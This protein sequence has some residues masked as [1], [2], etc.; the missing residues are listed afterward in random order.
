V[1]LRLLSAALSAELA[2]AIGDPQLTQNFSTGGIGLGVAVGGGTGWTRKG[3]TGDG[4]ARPLFLLITRTATMMM[5]AKTN[6][7]L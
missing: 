2:E 7:I 5:P 1:K 3:N 4:A 6:K